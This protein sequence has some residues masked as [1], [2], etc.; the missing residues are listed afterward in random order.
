MLSTSVHML[1]AS[2]ISSDDRCVGYTGNL[3]HYRIISCA[4]SY[5]YYSVTIYGKIGEICILNRTPILA[6]TMYRHQWPRHPE[7]SGH[8]LHHCLDCSVPLHTTHRQIRPP[9]APDR[10]EPREHGYI[11]HSNDSPRQ[12]PTRRIYEPWCSMGLYNRH[13]DI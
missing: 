4:N 10:W 5:Q 7:I 8:Q 13:V 2:S 3:S 1:C 6:D 9:E 11:H 12:I